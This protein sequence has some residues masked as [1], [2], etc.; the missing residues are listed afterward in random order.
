[1]SAD[2]ADRH[3]IEFL[4][5]RAVIVQVVFERERILMSLSPRPAGFA[6]LRTHLD[7]S[8]GF[9]PKI[10]SLAKTT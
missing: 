9:L 1:V 4:D 2:F 7:S 6:S 8:P 5:F 10:I 3:R